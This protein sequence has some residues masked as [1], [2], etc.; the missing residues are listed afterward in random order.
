M[1]N[2]SKKTSNNIEVKFKKRLKHNAWGWAYKDENRIEIKRGLSEVDELDTTI[3]EL[4]HIVYPF[5]DE[6]WVERKS[7]IIAQ[8]LYELGWRK[9][10]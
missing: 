8:H 9:Q 10:P 6:D 3:H 4:I 7:T 1:T 2:K 5:L